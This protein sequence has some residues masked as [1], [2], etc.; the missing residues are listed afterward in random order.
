MNTFAFVLDFC[1]SKFSYK[2]CIIFHAVKVSMYPQDLILK[3]IS[4]H[5]TLLLKPFKELLYEIARL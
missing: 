3:L 2:F 4:A 1:H 5:Y